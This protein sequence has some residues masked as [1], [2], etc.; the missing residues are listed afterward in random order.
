MNTKKIEKSIRYSEE[1]DTYYVQFNF[2]PKN[3]SHLRGFPTLEDARVYRDAINAA[4]L[5]AKIKKDLAIIYAYEDELIKDYKPYPY[6]V[7][8]VAGLNVNEIEL[9][10]VNDFEGIL[11]RTC[12]EKEAICIRT[13]FQHEGTMA[14]IGKEL[15]VTKQRVKQI[16]S[17]GTRQIASYI[18]EQRLD[19]QTKKDFESVKTTYANYPIESLGFSL[20]TYNALTRNNIRTVAD[21]LNYRIP[22]IR[23][24]RGLGKKTFKEV[25]IKIQEMGFLFKQK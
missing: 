3:E 13:Y 15:G 1:T 23:K 12:D 18:F 4:K 6:N 8:E 14:E 2:S 21:L 20:R 7:F 22:E 11:Q 19:K 17:K 5:E 9:S 16:I 25:A 24:F 10:I